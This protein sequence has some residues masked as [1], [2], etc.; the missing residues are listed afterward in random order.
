MSRSACAAECEKHTF[1][2]LANI[3]NW[4]TGRSSAYDQYELRLNACC[5]NAN[6][7]DSRK[8][9]QFLIFNKSL[10]LFFFVS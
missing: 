1:F 6:G 8:H 7:L 10:L 9:L 4:D 3:N 2:S 5:S